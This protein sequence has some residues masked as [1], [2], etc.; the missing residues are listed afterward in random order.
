M[1]HDTNIPLKQT[2]LGIYRLLGTPIYLSIEILTGEK[3]SSKCDV[4]SCGILLYEMLY[5][6]HPFF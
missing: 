6:S 2:L 3:Y 5:G 4:F 1:V